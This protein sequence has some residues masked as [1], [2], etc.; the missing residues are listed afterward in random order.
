MN[1]LFFTNLVVGL[2]YCYHMDKSKISKIDILILAII[3]FNLFLIG[4]IK[5]IFKKEKERSS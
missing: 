3:I 2:L 1:K 4:K 5:N